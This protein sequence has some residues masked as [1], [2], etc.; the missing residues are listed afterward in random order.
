MENQ[1]ELKDQF[2]KYQNH[3]MGEFIEITGNKGDSCI[4]QGDIA[5]I[6]TLG[7][8]NII[9]TSVLYG[10]AEDAER[11]K[12]YEFKDKKISLHTEIKNAPVAISYYNDNDDKLCGQILKNK[13][14]FEI[15][16]GKN[17]IYMEANNEKYT[18]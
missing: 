14:S 10:N 6:V 12:I 1:Q 11:L 17:K 2:N 5:C 7:S 15:C 16:L 9:T 8:A 4:N 13:N 3:F 18:I